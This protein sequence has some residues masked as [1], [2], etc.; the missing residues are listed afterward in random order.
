MVQ[1]GIKFLTANSICLILGTIASLIWANY[2]HE[3]YEH[4]VHQEVLGQTLHFWITDVCMSMF[5]MLAAKEIWESF[6]PG[7]SLSSIRKAA[8]PLLATA[9]GMAFPAGIYALCC[10]AFNRPEAMRGWAIPCATDIAFSYMVAKYVFGARHVAIPFLLLIA[11][12]DDAGGLVVLAVFYP[13]HELHLLAFFCLVSTAVGLGLALHRMR[14][15]TSW[16]Y[17]VPGA[18]SWFAFYIGGL[19]PALGL[20]PIVA[21]I[22]HAKRDRGLFEETEE[23]RHTAL[24]QLEHIWKRPVEVILGLFALV[25]AG[26][27][28]SSISEST[29]FVL[30][31]LLIGKPLGIVV[32][33]LFAVTVL[34][35]QMPDGMQYRDLVVLG[36]AA[37]I[38]FTVSLF[39]AV[40]AFPQGGP[41]LDGAKMGAL[42]SF[43]GGVLTILLARALGITKMRS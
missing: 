37:G 21:T 39:V 15:H 34:R 9:G 32:C 28:L 35:L 12:A 25:N 31:A 11:V 18:I 22:P 6:L 16:A 20:V 7:G 40:T 19:H 8:T 4:F 30:S 14:V 42:F 24:D 17:L 27:Q 26:V 29:F 1:R 5:F 43:S 3:Q 10:I 23:F 33:T 41:A 13:Q 2:D 36:M 38:G